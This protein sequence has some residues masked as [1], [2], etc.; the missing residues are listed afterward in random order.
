MKS[1]LII[2]SM[3]LMIL[4]IVCADGMFISDEIRYL[5]M[6][7]QKAIITWDGTT[8]ELI[9][10]SAVRSEN[11]SNMAWII[12]IESYTKPE[13][14][15]SN[16][17]I[18]KDLVEYLKET[19]RNI[20]G[21]F[22]SN[23][24]GAI[25]Q[26]ISILEQKEEDIYDITIIKS[27]NSTALME[28]LNRNGYNAPPE[29]KTLFDEYSKNKNMYFI[30]NKIDLKNKYKTEIEELSMAIENT[31]TSLM[32]KRDQT[33]DEV[34]PKFETLGCTIEKNYSIYMYTEA[35]ERCE[36]EKIAKKL[37]TERIPFEVKNKHAYSDKEGRPWFEFE[38]G[39]DAGWQFGGYGYP[40]H[41][42]IWVTETQGGENL[43]REVYPLYKPE[44]RKN[45]DYKT[46]E[47]YG[48]IIREALSE[49]YEAFN[50]INSM[51][52]DDERRVFGVYKMLEK[53]DIGFVCRYDYSIDEY[54][55][56]LD[57]W[58]NFTALCEIQQTLKRGMAT[59]LKFTFQPTEPYYPLKISSLGLGHTN[60]VV[61]FLS[62]Y[63]VKEKNKLMYVEKVKKI[64][65]NLKNKLEKDISVEKTGYVTRLTWGG[66]LDELSKDAIFI[67]DKEY[68]EPK[69]RKGFFSWLSG[70][71]G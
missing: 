59:P 2:L 21:I 67:E 7:D 33:F 61:Y 47:R 42:V 39:L 26:Q 31:K 66:R 23:K 9:I 65:Q 3:F 15:A 36:I 24:A 41:Y 70:L 8:E 57:T 4:P 50:E 54:N 14:E 69:G 16:I 49:N 52:Y 55:H 58:G 46:A 37:E 25:D 19:N 29:S 56:V 64:N 71:F 30:A 34:K 48:I 60:V 40:L 32:Q 63:P 5:E 62:E 22:G 13:V 6:P 17:S 35:R 18:F 51:T 10:A 45:N 27:E 38:D 12:P 20:L 68:V 53:G 44:I 43:Y 11:I 1:K 28:W